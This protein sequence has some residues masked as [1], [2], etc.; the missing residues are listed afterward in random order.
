MFHYNSHKIISAVPLADI[1]KYFSELSAKKLSDCIYKY[2]GLE[3]EITPYSD[4]KLP[5]LG[6][7]RHTIEVRGDKIPAEQFLTDFRFRFLSAG[8]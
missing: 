3:I 7:L 5:D 2:N 4:D 6:I 8:G 1:L